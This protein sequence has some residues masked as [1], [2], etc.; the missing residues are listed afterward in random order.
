MSVIKKFEQTIGQIYTILAKRKIIVFGTGEGSYLTIPILA[1]YGLIADY[2][3]D[4]N[5]S[6]WGDMHLNKPIFSPKQLYSEK[7]QEIFILIASSYYH[8]IEKQLK[9]DYN[10]EEGKHYCILFCP[11]PDESTRNT[12]LINGVQVGKYSYGYERL[13]KSYPDLLKS[14]GAFCSINNTV[15]IAGPNHP[16]QYIST[17][18][19]FYNR[20]IHGEELVPPLLEND[21]ALA[22]VVGNNDKIII[23]H[24]VWIGKGALL[25][26]S[27]KIGNGAIIGTGAVVTKDVPN[28][29]IVAGVPAKV[30]RYR[31]KE[32]EIEQLNAIEWW[33]WT[34]EQIR[35]NIHYFVKNKEF[36][37]K[38]G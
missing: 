27:I 36:L 11:T 5:E 24:D 15:E 35:E 21:E 4:N 25:L 26:P 34:D 19:F 7:K 9:G 23:G 10:L 22:D 20:Q 38:F 17:H 37:H 1:Q 31:F 3:L 28:Y 30:I 2:Y 18:P 12:R 6:R 14:I 29:A 8:E 32:T 33:D 16:A 13:C